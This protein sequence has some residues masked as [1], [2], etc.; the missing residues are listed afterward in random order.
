MFAVKTQLF[1]LPLPLLVFVPTVPFF[2]LTEVAEEL[3]RTASSSSIVPYLPRL[4]ML[5]SKTRTLKKQAE[6]KENIEGTQ[7][8]VE[9]S[10]SSSAPGMGTGTVAVRPHVLGVNSQRNKEQHDSSFVLLCREC[11]WPSYL[12]ANRKHCSFFNVLLVNP[13]VFFLSIS[14][15]LLFFK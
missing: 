15:L 4:P 12:L 10:A 3:G 9:H 5:P 14:V 7:D 1:F 8:T 2:Y 11:C 13:I 6:N